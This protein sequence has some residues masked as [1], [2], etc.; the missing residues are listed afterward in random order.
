MECGYFTANSWSINETVWAN[1]NLDFNVSF[2]G[3][4]EI[5]KTIFIGGSML[6]NMSLIINPIGFFPS[7]IWYSFNTGI[8]IS[9]FEIGFRH[10]C[11][12][13]IQPYISRSNPGNVFAEG[14]FEEIYMKFKGSIDLF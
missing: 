2:T 11:F 4:I 7:D 6:T 3:E 12:H 5:L 9:N 10:N 14:G 8:R 1:K 13:P